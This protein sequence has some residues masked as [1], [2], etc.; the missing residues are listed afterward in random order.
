MIVP[1]GDEAY[2]LSER[3]DE[4]SEADLFD[5]D[6]AQAIKASNRQAKVGTRV[7]CPTCG[8]RFTK[9]SYQH[10]FCRSKGRGNCKDRFHNLASP[11]RLA[12]ARA[13]S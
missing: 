2:A 5:V 8:C 1:N 9:R 4:P 10:V 6:D 12:R 13:W 7:I 3:Y 11:E